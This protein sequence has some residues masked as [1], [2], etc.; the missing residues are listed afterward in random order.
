MA[1]G[2]GAAG[3]PKEAASSNKVLEGVGDC[4]V[5]VGLRRR[6][7][8]RED[9]HCGHLPA[10]AAGKKQAPAAPAADPGRRRTGGRQAG[11]GSS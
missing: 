9:V 1:A 2:A 7:G 10:P 8:G 4:V 3:V 6:E 11:G 5:E